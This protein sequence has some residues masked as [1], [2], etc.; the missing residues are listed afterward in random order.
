MTEDRA[1]PGD[2]PTA[3]PD[4]TAEAAFDAFVAEVEGR[5]RRALV[6]VA[7]AEAARDAT[8]DALVHAW[9]HWPRVRAMA[10]PAGYV[11]TV[12][13]SRVRLPDRPVDALP[14]GLADPA[15][16]PEVEPRLAALLAALPERQR[17]ALYLLHGCGWPTP[18]VAD[19][20]G[21]SVSTVRNHVARALERL[22]RELGVD[23]PPPSPPKDG[24]QP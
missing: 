24:E 19:L 9:R 20:L 23:A 18:E 11:Y 7:G 2:A 21:V 3:E 6:P 8:A 22:R 1:Q 13:R 5:V 15:A 14:A 10:N 4:P 17:V 12:A 16:A